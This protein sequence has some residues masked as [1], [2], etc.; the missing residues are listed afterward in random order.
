MQTPAVQNSFDLL[1]QVKDRDF[2]TKQATL[3]VTVKVADNNDPPVVPVQTIQ[4]IEDAVN[5]I[6]VLDA[7]GNP[8]PNIFGTITGYADDDTLGASSDTVSYALAPTVVVSDRN[9]V[10][11]STFSTITA[12]NFA[13]NATTGELRIAAPISLGNII[14]RNYSVIDGRAVR[15]K[16]VLT[17]SATDSKSILRADGVTMSPTSRVVPTFPINVYVMINAS[18]GGEAIVSSAQ[19]IDSATG[20]PLST[21]TADTAGCQALRIQGE[22]FSNVPLLRGGD[23]NVNVRFEALPSTSL[24]GSSPQW[25]MPA[26]R[27][28]VYGCQVLDD[29]NIYCTGRQASTAITACMTGSTQNWGTSPGF[30]TNLGLVVDWSTSTT[31]KIMPT[32]SGSPIIV[33]YTQPTISTIAFDTSTGKAAPQGNS[34]FGFSTDG[35]GALAIS[36]ANTGPLTSVIAVTYGIMGYEY[37]AP[38]SSLTPSTLS[39]PGII[40]AFMQPGAGTNLVIKVQV[41]DQTATLTGS[42]LTQGGLIGYAAPTI[43]GIQ[44]S[45]GSNGTLNALTTLQ[46]T[47]PQ[48]IDIVGRNFGRITDFPAVVMRYSANIA[49]NGLTNQPWTAAMA[50]ACSKNINTTNTVVTCTVPNGFGAGWSVY[51]T[52]GNQTSAVSPTTLSYAAP[53]LTGVSGVGAT[54]ADTAGGQ[55]VILIGSNFGPATILDVSR[56]PAVPVPPPM[57]VT[58]STVSPYTEYVAVN[59]VPV[60]TA[61]D[62]QISCALA[63]GSGKNLYWSLSL[64]G[65]ATVG[66]SPFTTNYAA[67]VIVSL[68]SSSSV[69]NTNNQDYLTEG[70]STQQ[71]YIDGTNFGQALN[72][73]AMPSAFKKTTTVTYLQKLDMPR[74]V[75]NSSLGADSQGVISYTAQNCVL[76]VEHYQIRCDLQPGAGLGLQWTV[77]VN[78]QASTEPLMGYRTPRI[79]SIT[80]ADSSPA[81]AI[82]TDGGET[83]LITGTDFG[84]ASPNCNTKP[85]SYWPAAGTTNICTGLIQQLTYGPLGSE[86]R[87]A[88]VHIKSSTQI[89]VRTRPGFGGPFTA[90][91]QVADQFSPAAGVFGYAKPYVTG[92]MP[93]SGP[94]N[95]AVDS[96]E[97]RITG[98]N[99]GLNDPL[100]AVSVLFGNP[101]D[102]TLYSQILPTHAPDGRTPG[103]HAVSFFLPRGLMNFRAVRVIVHPLGQPNSALRVISD[104]MDVRSAGAAFFDYVAPEIDNVVVSA[105]PNNNVAER[106]ALEQWLINNLAGASS[107]TLS[108]V[109]KLVVVGANF[110]PAQGVNGDNVVR[111]VMYLGQVSSTPYAAIKA[112]DDNR[113]EMY[114]YQQTGDIYVQHQGKTY[115]NN[116]LMRSSNVFSYSRISPQAIKASFVGLN[117]AGGDKIT[118][119]FQF[120]ASTLSSLEVY[121]EVASDAN[122]LPVYT[123][124]RMFNPTTHAEIDPT[125]QASVAAYINAQVAAAPSPDAAVFPLEIMVPAGDGVGRKIFVLRDAS[126]KSDAA[127]IT[128][129]YAA[130]VIQSFQVY[131]EF[132]STWGPVMDASQTIVLP[133]LGTKIK[134]NGANFGL[135][136]SVAMTTTGFVGMAGPGAAYPLTLPQYGTPASGAVTTNLCAAGSTGAPVGEPANTHTNVTMWTA[137]GQGSGKDVDSANGYTLSFKVSGQTS[138]IVRTRYMDP[139]ITSATPTGRTTGG[140][141]LTIQGKNLGATSM[142]LSVNLVKGSTVVACT[143]ATL[144]AP[145]ANRRTDAAYVICKIPEGSGAGYDIVLSTTSYACADSTVQCKATR[146]AGFDYQKPAISNVY[147]QGVG[148]VSADWSDPINAYAAWVQNGAPSASAVAAPAFLTMAVTGSDSITAYGSALAAMNA[149]GTR[150]TGTPVRLPANG[151]YIVTLEGDN[152]G[153]YNT[154][155]H[156]LFFAWGGRDR[157]APL[158]CN[159]AIDTVGEN[160]IPALAILH[161][162]HTRIVIVAPSG[163]GGREIIVKVNGVEPIVGTPMHYK[164]PVITRPLDPA[165]GGTDGGEAVTVYGVNFGT[166]PIDTTSPSVSAAVKG[167][168]GPITKPLWP[169]KLSYY[170]TDHQAPQAVT[171]INFFRKCMSA[172]LDKDGAQPPVVS[173]CS[174]PVQPDNGIQFIHTDSSI[175]FETANGI[176]VHRAVTVEIWDLNSTTGAW[177]NYTSD[178]VFF[179]YQKP[180]VYAV[181]NNPIK[182]TQDTVAYEIDLMGRNLGNPPA[183]NSAAD[184][185]SDA[186][187]LTAVTVDGMPCVYGAD[188]NTGADLRSVSGTAAHP[189]VELKCY[190][191]SMT[192]GYHNLSYTVAGQSNGNPITAVG[193]IPFLVCRANYFGYAGEMCAACPYGAKCSG[194]VTSFVDRTTA[195][196]E[197][198]TTTDGGMHTYPRPLAGF[199]NLNS[200]NQVRSL[201][202]LLL[203]DAPAPCRIIRP[204]LC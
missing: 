79:L 95:P 59:C 122:N 32:K 165:T 84:P 68:S 22:G 184:A 41:G 39:T 91:V 194:F 163:T 101:S 14:D 125:N 12:A 143:N 61:A 74:N 97:V 92:V 33:A 16:V 52:V 161:W 170:L 93:T 89:L 124:A 69:Y 94:T 114:S 27:F 164:K 9:G 175:S 75:L 102:N 21:Q 45:A 107:S 36:V 30:G 109:L 196:T 110:G 166:Y 157:A 147:Y 90:T 77:T 140:D 153:V 145:A 142:G 99:F 1:V 129:S 47:T 130:P 49:I 62:R 134:V 54:K 141:T 26:R 31:S 149:T 148:N 151:G 174:A 5:Q 197:L 51:V 119:T 179:D 10:K 11:G 167:S 123:R 128:L 19:F 169:S 189:V 112:W 139:T 105:L 3:Q 60:L 87:F 181:A 150:V 186:E 127:D 13:I 158:T 171:R 76:T 67:P 133:T 50:P 203:T 187:K 190:M 199:Y 24:V 146:P 106:Q 104:P 138:A 78:T 66:P 173:A 200:S 135:C 121:V 63:P 6:T 42:A 25:S 185:W 85:A 82:S 132:T 53:V 20:N 34:L 48:R 37:L 55:E 198:Q 120:L 156:C 195:A 188:L 172:Y 43:T 144:L 86:Y 103:A 35:N 192:V 70:G 154:A 40:R 17:G 202:L 58:Y 183:N 71:V 64:V 113:I 44:L 131:D 116:D 177:F 81:D 8:V 108:S 57:S 56:T 191:P 155:K 65:Q 100:T 160:E 118:V 18:Y 204:S 176:G 72:P 162:S 29:N 23:V 28:P 111:G 193:T 136:P 201:V 168:A 88:D 126:D 96:V 117:T 178:P 137:P 115:D 83:L 182:M 152:F 180:Q 159:G 4:I 80:M 2:P 73:L 7:R 98:A 15:Y 46:S 38:L